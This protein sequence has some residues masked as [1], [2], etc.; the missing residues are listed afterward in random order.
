MKCTSCGQECFDEK[1]PEVV[2]K[3]DKYCI[4]EECSID[5]EENEITGKVQFRQDL[6]EDGCIEQHECHFE[7]NKYCGAYVC[8]FCGKHKGL[9]RCYCGWSETSPGRG[10]QELIDMGENIDDDY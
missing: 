6:I 4:C 10:R 2:F 8:N 7:F 5:Y 1:Y 3:D 9:A